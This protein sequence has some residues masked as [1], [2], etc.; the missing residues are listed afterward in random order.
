[1]L[2]GDITIATVLTTSLAEL[3][4]DARAQADL[5]AG[6]PANVKEAARKF[7]TDPKNKIDIRMG[8]TTEVPKNPQI[9]IVLAGEEETNTPIGGHADAGYE[10]Y[11]ADRTALTVHY[12]GQHVAKLQIDV[13]RG[14]IRTEIYD[15]G[16]PV[17]HRVETEE[18]SLNLDDY[19][20][21]TL[22]ADAINAIT[23]Y[24]VDVETDFAAL[25]PTLLER[26]DLAYINDGLPL[27]VVPKVW[28]ELGGTFFR[29]TWK[30]TALSINANITLWLHA[31]IKWALLK[32]RIGLEMAGLQS[33]QLAGGDFEPA[34]EWVQN[35]DVAVFARGVL[36]TA[37]YF[38]QFAD[39]S[40]A[41]IIK[42]TD[43]H[44]YTDTTPVGYID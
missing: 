22:L 13:V 34:P 9:V 27:L 10:E 6:A 26:K 17:L 24:S 35:N 4:A 36:L 41:V 37:Y 8:F 18:F 38:A 44:E 25:D 15:L 1:V 19:A 7:F 23:N 30:I 33:A 42:Y 2:I 16:N 28:G 32:E 20:T 11:D 31:F 29:G 12:T 39:R 5:L 14:V 43:V 21:I 3:R 40:D